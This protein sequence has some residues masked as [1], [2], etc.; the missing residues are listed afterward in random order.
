VGTT[1][2]YISTLER[3]PANMSLG[4]LVKLLDA[5]GADFDIRIRRRGLKSRAALT[6]VAF[7]PASLEPTR[8]RR[9]NDAA[10]TVA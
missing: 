3:G 6:Q 10:R 9:A 4:Y 2:E 1:R 8:R 5:L 7:P